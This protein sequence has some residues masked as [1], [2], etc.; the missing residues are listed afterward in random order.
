M[1]RSRF[2]YLKYFSRRLLEK[3]FV[4]KMGFIRKPKKF[5]FG[6]KVPT[7]EETNEL[8]ASYIKSG[9]P[10]CLLRPGNSEFS[11]AT[12]WDEHVLFGT[13]RYREHDMFIEID[14]LENYE[15]G[16]RWVEQFEKDLGEADIFA[17]FSTT[18]DMELYLVEA[19]AK[20]SKFILLPQIEAIWLDRPWLQELKGKKVLIISPFVETMKTQYERRKLIWE[21]HDILP[22]MDVKY[23]KSVWYLGNDDG[24]GFANWFEALDYLYTAASKIDFDIALLGCGPFSTFLAAAFKRDGKQAIHYGGALQLLFGIRG[25]RWDEMDKYKMFY[26]EYWVRPSQSDAPKKADTLDDKCYW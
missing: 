15:Y 7:N 22:D 3:V 13:K 4:D 19:Y 20:D 25:A 12:K 6:E 5:L 9:E 10:F 17:C 24:D 8:I 16:K 11:L 1:D 2:L 18:S 26:N 14:G 23:L 21:G